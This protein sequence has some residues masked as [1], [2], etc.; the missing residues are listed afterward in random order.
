MACID[1]SN[2][3]HCSGCFA[4]LQIC[5]QK[6]TTM[7]YD[8]EGFLYP[9]VD[10]QNCI[11]CGLCKK[12]CPMENEDMFV[13]DFNPP[14]TFGGWNN[15]MNIKMQS[16]SGG[17]FSTVAELVLN[18]GGVVF[19]AVFDDN[20]KLKHIM[21]DDVLN[22]GKLRGSKYVQ[23][24]IGNTYI[25]AKTELENDRNV[26]F[27]GTPCQIGG[28]YAFLNKKYD[29]LITIDLVCHG[30]PSPKIFKDYIGGLEQKYNSK[31][32]YLNFRDKRTGWNSG[33][34]IKAEFGNSKEYFVIGYKDNFITGFLNDMY[35]RPSCYECNFS[36]LPRVADISL[37]DFWGV[38]NYYPELD[39]N[40]GTSL[41]LVNN[42]KGKAMIEKCKNKLILKLVDYKLALKHNPCIASSV[43]QNRKR[44][45]FFRNYNKKGW[46]YVERKYLKPPFIKKV[47]NFPIRCL[48]FAKRKVFPLL[49][50]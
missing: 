10:K 25:Q 50:G 43:I 48:R 35:L 8:N 49:I 27:V 15:N 45:Q 4:C 6:C 11:S 21:I 34:S 31:I 5:P 1:I 16:S 9:N 39:D 41:I 36:K 12:T 38:A 29:G 2:K 30:V 23:S 18:Q 42:I 28:L 3:S 37:G 13:N 46:K 44:E 7:E 32:S 33:I 47:L 40:K 14:V 22:L 19:G 24:E 26:L 17:V 20:I